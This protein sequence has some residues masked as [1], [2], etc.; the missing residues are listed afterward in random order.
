M[1]EFFCGQ[2][3]ER[4]TK[5]H[6]TQSTFLGLVDHRNLVLAAVSCPAL[7]SHL[8][9]FLFSIFMPIF[10]ETRRGVGDLEGNFGAI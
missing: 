2:P 9:Q 8:L 3:I 6:G 7:A 1:T 4:G 10:L 5:L